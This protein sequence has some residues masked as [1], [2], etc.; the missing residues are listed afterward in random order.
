[1]HE[2]GI[3][4]NVVAI[5]CEHAKGQRIRR[6]LLEVGK[7]SAVMPDAI[8]FCFEICAKGTIVEGAELAIEEVAGLGVCSDCGAELALDQASWVCTCGSRNVQCV[9]G[10]ELK[11]K[12]MEVE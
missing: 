4:Q 10:L 1:M 12:E 11:V 9:A 5:V 7:L 2:L 6:V 8:S 3:A